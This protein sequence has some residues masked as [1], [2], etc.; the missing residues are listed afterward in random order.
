MSFKAYDTEDLRALGRM[1]L[2][3]IMD[4][5]ALRA[6]FIRLIRYGL[7]E[8][9]KS[10]A[11]RAEA[12]RIY[13]RAASECG[14]ERNVQLAQTIILGIGALSEDDA[15]RKIALVNEAS[16]LTPEQQIRAM[17]DRIGELVAEQP[18]LRPVA[19]DCVATLLASRLLLPP[20]ANGGA[21]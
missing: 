2:G 20:H 14:L 16:D 15:R 12:M 8:Q 13:Y 4:D 7:S 1:A 17:A 11:I 21:S 18:A 19:E 3:A 6:D 9:C 5:E 10:R